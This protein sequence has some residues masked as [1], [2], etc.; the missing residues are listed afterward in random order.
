MALK[1]V[2]PLTAENMKILP[3]A[4][5]PVEFSL[6]LVVALVI[7]AIAMVALRPGAGKKFMNWFHP[8]YLIPGCRARPI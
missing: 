8:E 3:D 4:A 5:P 7:F 2:I 6:A 1:E